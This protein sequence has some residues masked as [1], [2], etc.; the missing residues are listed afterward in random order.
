M[1]LKIFWLLGFIGIG[2]GM[3]LLGCTIRSVTTQ[4][5]AMVRAVVGWGIFMELC[6]FSLGAFK[7]MLS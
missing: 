2:A 5:T 6:W 7:F 3:Y 4:D 1:D